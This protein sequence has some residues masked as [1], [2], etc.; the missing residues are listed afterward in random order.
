MHAGCLYE[1]TADFGIEH[2][3]STAEMGGSEAAALDLKTKEGNGDAQAMSQIVE[4]PAKFRS[5]V[6]GG[7]GIGWDWRIGMN[8]HDDEKPRRLLSPDERALGSL[9]TTSYI[10]ICSDCVKTRCT[11]RHHAS[12]L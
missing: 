8:E 9:T 2:D 1:V 10:A 7:F 4:G 12:G 6:L 3:D 5:N 11:K